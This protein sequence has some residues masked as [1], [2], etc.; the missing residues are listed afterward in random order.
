MA[1]KYEMD[2][3]E[4]PLLSKIIKFSIPVILTSLLQLLYNAVDIIVVGRYVGSTALAAVGSTS[5][6]INLLVNA[7][8]GLSV[9]TGV[10]LAQS[11]GAN[12]RDKAH[13][14][15][16][17]AMLTSLIIGVVVGVFGFLMCRPMLSLMGSPDD[18]IDQS[19][20]YMKIYFLGMPA[21]MVY[22]FGSAIMRTVGDTKRPLF[23]LSI[24]GVTNVILN[25]VLVLK[26]NM[27][28]AGVAIATIVSQYISAIFVI[29]SLINTDGLCRLELKELKIKGKTLA[30]IIKFGLPVAIQ[31]SIFSISNV[32]IQTSVNSFGS[33]VIAGNSAAMNIEGFLFVVLNSGGQAATTFAG[34][35][36]GAK[37]FKRVNLTLIICLLLTTGISVIAGPLIYSFGEP[38]LKIYSP[39]NLVAVGYGMIRLKYICLI[40]GV[41]GIM[42]VFVGVI[43]ATGAT[44]KPMLISI[45][46]VCGVRIIWIYTV[47]KHFQTL[48]SLYLSYLVS[49]T[50][51]SIV[52]LFT[53]LH[54]KKKYLKESKA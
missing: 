11:I 47:F 28:V 10:V 41:C 46:G 9:G 20:L 38:L 40:Y 4:G 37:K 52:L 42:E 51:T 34:Q 16:H 1:A 29:L 49:W 36:Y 7:F 23:F 25:L 26:F 32:L 3:C 24:S 43:R 54:I 31:N 5:P 8:I 2:M 45:F 13:N 53:Y 21:F 15:V 22:T 17:T 39:K 44:V 35:N 48:E 6:L 27:G 12:N 30:E 14:I 33:D 18:V 50:I 19:T